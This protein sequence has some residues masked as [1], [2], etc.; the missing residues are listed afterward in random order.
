MYNFIQTFEC[1]ACHLELSIF[2]RQFEI[3]EHAQSSVTEYFSIFQQNSLEVIQDLHFH[4]I[5][6]IKPQKPVIY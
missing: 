4:Q 1:V 6:G 2:S 3:T 5:M